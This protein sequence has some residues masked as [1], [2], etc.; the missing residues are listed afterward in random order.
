MNDTP[1][2]GPSLLDRS[3]E[4]YRD[5]SDNEAAFRR[6]VDHNARVLWALDAVDE[7]MSA[8]WDVVN[9]VAGPRGVRAALQAHRNDNS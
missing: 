3:R 8:L 5:L 1:S 2:D 7:T 6:L 4:T 9:K